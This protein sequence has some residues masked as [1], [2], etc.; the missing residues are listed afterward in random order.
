MN[1]IKNTM[2]DMKKE[3]NEDIEI[4]K[5]KSI[6]NKELNILNTNLIQKLDDNRVSETEDKVEE[7]AQTVNNHEKIVFLV[8]PTKPKLPFLI[9]EDIK[10]FHNKQKLKEFTTIKPVLQKILKG[11]LNTEEIILRQKDARKNKHFWPSRSVNKEE[12]KSKQQ[13]TINDCKHH[14][15]LNTSTE[16]QWPQCPSQK[17]ME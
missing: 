16:S 5:T 4:Q 2:Q 10:I 9:K 15:P 13:E 3:I 14:A 8:L 12:V 17:D 11:L 1:E 6:W 7:L